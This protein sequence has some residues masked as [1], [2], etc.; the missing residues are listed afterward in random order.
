MLD[1]WHKKQKP[2][3]TG[4][5]RGIGGFA[6]GHVTGGAGGGGCCIHSKQWWC[7]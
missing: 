2:V 1:K 4:I 3:F 5:A 6:F 7:N